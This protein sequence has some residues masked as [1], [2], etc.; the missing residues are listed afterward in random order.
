MKNYLS[1]LKSK[2]RE[3]LRYFQLYKKK[4][5]IGF[6]EYWRL[7]FYNDNRETSLFN[8]PI[9]AP[10][11][12]W[13]LHSLYE[14]FIE[15]TYKFKTSNPRPLII[16]CGSNVGLSIIYFKRSHPA[17]RVIGFEPDPEIFMMMQRNLKQF[18]FSGV[19]LVNK[20][21]WIDEGEL[22]FNSSGA[23]GG[24]IEFK[25]STTK[26]KTV[27]ET[28]R[29]KNYLKDQ[30]IDFLKIDVEGAE[31]EIVNDCLD[32]LSNV[33]RIFIE[34]HRANGAQ[35]LAGEFINKLEKAGFRV[36][37]KEAWNN[38]PHPYCYEDYKPM[39]DLQLNIFGYRTGA[40]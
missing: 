12:F 22:S 10:D 9:Q 33:D 17:A 35:N 11:A 14:I 29:L 8:K 1:Y 32:E 3:D 34:Y 2:W 39:Y 28:V 21:V 24:A 20:A 36:Y 26:S 7:K 19:E 38:L 5:G 6:A 16:D 37:I 18:E 27:V 13:H 15:E 30:R 25:Q 23:L 31:F 4:T 40:A